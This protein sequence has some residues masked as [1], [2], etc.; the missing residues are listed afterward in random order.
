M[1]AQQDSTCARCKQS[2]ATT[3]DLSWHM[4][5]TVLC[6][7]PVPLE[8]MNKQEIT[9]L[10]DQ[11]TAAKAEI[12]RNSELIARYEAYVSDL[13]MHVAAGGLYK[14]TYT[15]RCGYSVQF[16]SCPLFL[17]IKDRHVVR[18]I[19]TH[20]GKED[21][22]V[23]VRIYY[24][25]GCN[26]PDE[27]Y[28]SERGRYFTGVSVLKVAI[29]EDVRQD[30]LNKHDNWYSAATNSSGIQQ[31]SEYQNLITGACGEWIRIRRDRIDALWALLTTRK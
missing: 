1:S 7:Q 12:A 4:T 15:V 6:V 10:R 24:D 26:L 18:R 8:E 14:K 28:K 17:L 11:Y 19:R 23:S 3:D 21:H 30:E 29:V 16:V 27:K 2:F 5:F 13:N 9:Y 20:T 31:M 25:D 22:V